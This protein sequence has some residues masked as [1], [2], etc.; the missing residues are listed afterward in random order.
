M[1]SGWQ[2]FPP[3]LSMCQEIYVRSHLPVLIYFLSTPF[4]CRQPIFSHSFHVSETLEGC[5]WLGSNSGCTYA[6][7]IWQEMSDGGNMSIFT[8]SRSACQRLAIYS[9]GGFSQSGTSG[10]WL[11]Q[12]GRDK[13]LVSATEVINEGLV[14]SVAVTP[15]T[16]CLVAWLEW[17]WH[18]LWVSSWEMF[19]ACLN[20][21]LS[22]QSIACLRNAGFFTSLWSL[23][24]CP[25]WKQLLNTELQMYKQLCTHTNTLC[26][27]SNNTQPNRVAAVRR[28][29]FIHEKYTTNH[30]W[31]KGQFSQKTVQPH[32]LS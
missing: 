13:L 22:P 31:Q 26:V 10:L 27:P 25:Q 12:S 8:C 29:Q 7:F 4:C 11:W 15:L 14:H 28:N 1:A 19:S 3:L 18:R 16:K 23:H 17:F 20:S 2:P 6:P 32:L 24:S 5:L 21:I 9:N 30:D